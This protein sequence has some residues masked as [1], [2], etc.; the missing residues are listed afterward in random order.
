LFAPLGFV[1]INA[2]GGVSRGVDVARALALGA[3]AAGIARPVLK[4]LTAGGRAGAVAFLQ[5][6]LAELRAIM[7]LTGS[8][9]VAALRTAPRIIGPELR[10]WIDAGTPA[11]L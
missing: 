11:L 4:A 8:R 5:G 2:P 9:D 6:V 1:P 7:L 10:L 3:N